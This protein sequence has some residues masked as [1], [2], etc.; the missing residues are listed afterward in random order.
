MFKIAII[1]TLNVFI[2]YVFINELTNS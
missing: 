1:F 2:N